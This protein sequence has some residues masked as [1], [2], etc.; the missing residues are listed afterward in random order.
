VEV[1]VQAIIQS[2]LLVFASEMGDK[3][4]LLALVLATRFRKPWTIMA[5]ILAATLINHGLASWAGGW[6]A[7]QFPPIYV[8]WTLALIFFGFAAWILIPDK[9][10][11]LSEAYPYGAFLTTV[12]AFF[13]AEMGDKTQLATIALGARFTDPF[14]VTCGTTLGMLAADGLVVF[15]GEKLTNCVPMKYIRWFACG[16]FVLFGGFVLLH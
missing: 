6:V 5:G 13:L 10:E 14:A 3:T 2:F 16:L 7:E 9:E 15:F 8:K 12:I 11:D 1:S 4:Q